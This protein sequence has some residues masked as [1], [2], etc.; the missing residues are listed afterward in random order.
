MFG[1]VGTIG[2]I[3]P[4]VYTGYMHHYDDLLAHF[5]RTYYSTRVAA[6]WPQGWLYQLIGEHA[7]RVIRWL[8]LMA[9]GIGVTLFLR[10]RGARW[11]AY[12]GGTSVMFSAP[13]L[14]ELQEDYTSEVGIAYALLALPALTARSSWWALAG[15]ALA[16]LAINAHEGVAYLLIPL[17]V[18]AVVDI[19]FQRGVRAVLVRFAAAA[20]G[21]LLGQVALS[22][23]MG[24]TYGWE[25][26]NW[27]FQETSFNIAGQLSQG[28][29]QRWSVPWDNV[30]GRITILTILVGAWMCAALIV[31]ATRRLA[32]F[33][34]FIGIT[35]AS[36]LLIAMI[37]YSH[38]VVGSG[39]VGLPYYLVF[40]V[41]LSTVTA[42]TAVAAITRGTVARG[43]AIGTAT[44]VII[45]AFLLPI[46]NLPHAAWNALW[47]SG[48]GVAFAALIAAL[49][50]R[51]KGAATLSIMVG[52]V[53]LT[54]V[55]IPTAPLATGGIVPLTY[56]SV[57]QASKANTKTRAMGE[58]LHAVALNFIDY[59]HETIPST[60][61][62]LVYY[63]ARDV[64]VSIQSTTLL[65]YSCIECTTPSNPFPRFS[66]DGRVLAAN[67]QALVFMAST[68]GSIVA[69]QRSA[70]LLDPPFPTA[71]SPRNI[72]V[73]PI[74][75]W[76]GVSYQ[77]PA[78]SI[79]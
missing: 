53:V 42:W 65:G 50:L 46:A 4:W 16:S 27:L 52:A 17:L 10:Q 32:E 29:A 1:I 40:M 26:S 55:V 34:A 59:V 5:G 77:G 54:G 6:I 30:Y 45:I 7:Y 47:W 31:T 58:A 15:G 70:A 25:R 9:C 66:P 63:P 13:L 22:V 2:A 79:R 24:A 3:D 78:P 39:L 44:A 72:G 8:V 41:I 71:L 76:V 19:A 64:F 36:A 11:I 21:L 74:P 23:A 68:R 20:G 33:R 62:F 75:A 14:L 56:G 28:L 60:M 51:S 57:T 43:V 69:A 37:L 67:V 38:F 61:P 48:I 12:A 18:L 73:G 35:L 49:L